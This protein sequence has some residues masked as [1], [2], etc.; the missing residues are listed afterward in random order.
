M[1]LFFGLVPRCRAWSIVSR[2]SARR[3][4]QLTI[5]LTV[6]GTRR[7]AHRGHAKSPFDCITASLQSSHSSRSL[8][9][10]SGRSRSQRTTI[11][12][13]QSVRTR[14]LSNRSSQFYLTVRTQSSA[15]RTATLARTTTATATT[16]TPYKRRSRQHAGKRRQSSSSN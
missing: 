1:W 8:Q 14:P 2:A 5:T 11:N 13:E 15:T 9:E 3:E 10:R 4:E 7:T 12:S 6:A 16:L